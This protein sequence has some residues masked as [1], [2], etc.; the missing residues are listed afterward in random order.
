MQ[1]LSATD[2][3]GLVVITPPAIP[4]FLYVFGSPYKF[5]YVAEDAA[6]NRAICDRTVRL[7]CGLWLVGRRFTSCYPAGVSVH[8]SGNI[9]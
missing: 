7:L 6:G 3:T 1:D 9:V 5:T 4:E 2:S 8:A